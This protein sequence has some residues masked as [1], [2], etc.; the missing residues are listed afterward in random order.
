MH[1]G[2]EA[3]IRGGQDDPDAGA[4]VKV[5]HAGDPQEVH[6]GAFHVAEVDDV[7]QVSEAVLFAPGHGDAHTQGGEGRPPLTAVPS[8]AGGVGP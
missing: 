7:V 4:L 5:E 2:Q 6:A 8:G 1:R 3:A